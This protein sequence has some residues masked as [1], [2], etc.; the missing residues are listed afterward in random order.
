MI[1][2]L[3]TVAGELVELVKALQLEKA[4]QLAQEA[5]R[6]AVSSHLEGRQQ[7][8]HELTLA[9]AEAK[10][11]RARLFQEVVALPE[12]QRLFARAEVENICR[13]LF[14]AEIALLTTRKRQ[15]SRPTR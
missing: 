8:V 6:V 9:I 12:S 11:Q 13:S 5:R 4:R 10:R 1:A 3:P 2:D 14:D 15:L 7:T